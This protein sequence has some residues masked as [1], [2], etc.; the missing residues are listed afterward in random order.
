MVQIKQKITGW[1]VGEAEAAKPAPAEPATPVV[2][3][4]AAAAKVVELHESVARPDTLSGETYKIVSPLSEHAL[5]IT[6]NDIILGDGEHAHRRPFEVFVNSKNMD[7]FQWVV[8]LTRVMSAVFRKG[9]DVT[10]LVEELKAVFDPRGGYWQPGGVYVPSLVAAIGTVL[11]KHLRRLGMLASPELSDAQKA[12]I[13]E[14][15][16]AFEKASAPT[17]AVAVDEAVRPEAVPLEPAKETAGEFPPG[18]SMCTK[19][20]TKALVLLDGCQ[21]CLNCG[22]SKCN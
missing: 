19:C 10:F 12:L 21:T 13:A 5:Y 14:K 7:N 15:R 9:G 8:A 11:E 16:A 22:A 6:F 1:N 17:V 18:A 3:V 4:P 2:A 20:N